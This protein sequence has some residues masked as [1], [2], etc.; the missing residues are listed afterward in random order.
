[1]PK[2]HAQPVG[3]AQADSRLSTPHPVQ[4][5]GGTF[6][7][8]EPQDGGH[9]AARVLGRVNPPLP[10]KQPRPRRR[11]LNVTVKSERQTES[12]S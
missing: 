6:S 2:G 1:M 5:T 3:T 4:A 10:K 11:Q 8:F 9:T 7:P 12:Q